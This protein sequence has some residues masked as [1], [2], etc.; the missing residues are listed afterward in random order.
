MPSS[1][2]KGQHTDTQTHTHTHTHT[3]HIWKCRPNTNIDK[4]K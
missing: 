2:L 4:I 1:D 3:L